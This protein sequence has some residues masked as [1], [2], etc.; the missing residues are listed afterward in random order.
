MQTYCW[1]ALMLRLVTRQRFHLDLKTLIGSHTLSVRQISVCCSDD[2]KCLKLPLVPTDWHSQCGR[3]PHLG[4]VTYLLSL[5]GFNH[6]SNGVYHSSVAFSDQ[7][8]K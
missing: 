6:Y 5:A 7:Y 2:L 1:A 4:L 8:L 3:Y